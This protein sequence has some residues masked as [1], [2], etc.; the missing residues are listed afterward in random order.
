MTDPAH[1]LGTPSDIK[2][3]GALP[4]VFSA[5]ALM[6]YHRRLHRTPD[7]AEMDAVVDRG[8]VRISPP[9]LIFVAET[10][11]DC[12]LISG[13]AVFPLRRTPENTLVAVT[14]M[15]ARRMSKADRRAFRE[16]ARED[17]W[18]QTG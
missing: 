16:H 15:R 8:T 10:V 13:E 12:Y 1:G 3:L 2:S 5:H 14:C 6:R 9:S 18:E 4:I 17:R 11:A 7:D